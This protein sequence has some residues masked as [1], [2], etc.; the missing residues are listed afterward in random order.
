[1]WTLVLERAW[2]ASLSYFSSCPRAP[3][4]PQC[5]QCPAIPA[6]PACPACPGAPAPAAPARAA[7][8]DSSPVDL[9]SLLLVACLLV[10]ASGFCLSAALVSVW[11]CARRPLA[12]ARLAPIRDQ[13]TDVGQIAQEQLAALRQRRAG[14]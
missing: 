9:T 1:M 14:L 13:D 12:R 10:L 6:L 5:P 2:E 8:G 11:G 7:A 4:C 3:S